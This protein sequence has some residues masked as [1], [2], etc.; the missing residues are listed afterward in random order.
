VESLSLP[1]VSY[2]F[3]GSGSTLVAAALSG[4][5]YVGIELEVW[6][7]NTASSHSSGL[8]ASSGFCAGPHMSGWWQILLA[9]HA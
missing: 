8:L 9:G 1:A 2:P 6:R 3:A 7:S 4:R 5:R